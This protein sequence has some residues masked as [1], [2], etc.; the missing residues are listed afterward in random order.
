MYLKIENFIPLF[1]FF[2]KSTA[3]ILTIFGTFNRIIIII[4]KKTTM[5]QRIQSVF[6]L[7]SSIF[8]FSLFLKPVYFASR[9]SEMDAGATSNP[10]WADGKLNVHDSMIL[11]IF[12]ILAGVSAFAAIF[13]YKNR[14]LQQKVAY[15]SAVD[16]VV[17]AT[18]A[19]LM[20]SRY[21][22]GNLSGWAW[23]ADALAI[24]SALLAA[25]Y[26]RKDEQLV[27]SSD[28]LR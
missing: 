17:T 27:R 2:S 11:I 12:S 25:R 9:V 24:V 16:A 13:L 8:N 15:L 18:M 28:R 4:S 22:E 26:I 1:R 20:L 23:A 19:I 14:A 10:I 7:L 21:R 5:I 3:N 6:L